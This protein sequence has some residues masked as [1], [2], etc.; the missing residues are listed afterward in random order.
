MIG[1]GVTVG[2]GVAT[3]GAKGAVAVA[4]GV[5]IGAN[6]AV[7]VGWSSRVGSGVTTSP[8]QAASEINV[9]MI[10]KIGIVLFGITIFLLHL[11]PTA[12]RAL[13]YYNTVLLKMIRFIGAGLG[14]RFGWL[15]SQPSSQGRV[16]GANLACNALE[17]WAWS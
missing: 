4:R 3:G 10:D 2:V 9:T 6:V 1:V 15:R 12:R 7:W 8:R 17:T 5:G 13:L 16:L 11:K 14:H